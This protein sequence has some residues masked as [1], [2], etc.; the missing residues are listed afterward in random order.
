MNLDKNETL[1]TISRSYTTETACWDDL[2]ICYYEEVIS[3]FDPTVQF[4]LHDDIETLLKKW[5][6][7]PSLSEQVVIDFGCGIGEALPY[8]AGKVGWAI[9]LDFSLGM[10][11]QASARLSAEGIKHETL[12]GAD[13]ISLLAKEMSKSHSKSRMPPR[14]VLVH[15]NLLDLQALKHTC[16]LALAINSIVAEDLQQERQ[17]LRQITATMKPKAMLFAVFPSLDTMDHLMHL[18]ERSDH[19]PPE[20]GRIKGR[21]RV[22]VHTNGEVQKYLTPDEI[23]VLLD[24]VNLHPDLLEKVTYPWSLIQ[25]YGWGYYPRS[26]RLWDWYVMASKQKA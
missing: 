4:R 18:V 10:L 11:N 22:Y 16:N 8:F 15:G 17:M 12:L 26:R 23:I 3:V 1:S 25:K 19:L 24:H 6:G 9:G 7:R 2:S 20:L 21:D 13:A 14:T 5:T